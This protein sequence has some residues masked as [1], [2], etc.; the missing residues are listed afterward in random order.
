MYIFLISFIRKKHIFDFLIFYLKENEGTLTTY[1]I[2]VTKYKPY[3]YLQTHID[4]HDIHVGV[5][6]PDHKDLK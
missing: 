1:S 2:T 6:K 3:I 4:K 5:P